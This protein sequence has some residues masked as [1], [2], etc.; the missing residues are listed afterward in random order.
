M[1][2]NVTIVNENEPVKE[3]INVNMTY[4]QYIEYMDNIRDY[5]YRCQVESERNISNILNK[6]FLIGMYSFVALFFI[7]LITIAIMAK[8]L[9]KIFIWFKF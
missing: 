1:N 4:E 3:V 9:Q 2:R 6:D 5:N 8:M 7:L